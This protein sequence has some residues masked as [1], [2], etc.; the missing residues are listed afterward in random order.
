MRVIRDISR[1][2]IAEP[3]VVTMGN[4]DGVHQGHRA[5]I[6][7]VVERAKKKNALSAVITFSPHTQSYLSVGHSCHVLSSPNEKTALMEG[8]GVDYL[9]IL[10]FNSALRSMSGSEFLNRIVFR[11][12]KPFEIIYGRDH[13]FGAGRDGGEE[14]LRKLCRDNGIKAERMPSFQAREQ[15]VSSTLIRELVGMGKVEAAAELLG[16]P[17]LICGKVERGY[18]RGR[19]IGFPT[20]NVR[21]APEKLLMP[22]GVYLGR[23]G[24]ECLKETYPALISLGTRPTFGKTE[25]ALEVFLKGFSGDLY[26][27]RLCVEVEEFIRPQRRFDNLQKLQTAIKQDLRKLK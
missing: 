13:R 8:L 23:A 14:M 27:K 3:S 4:F 2:R 11:R 10:K 17:Y 22:D 19:K 7:R 6:Q 26:G 18:Q 16:H 24:R 21:V 20:A 9:V 12:L 5:I 25:R 1:F 15:V